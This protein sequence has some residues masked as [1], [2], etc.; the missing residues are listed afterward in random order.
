VSSVLPSVLSTISEQFA[1][2]L[3]DDRSASV[4]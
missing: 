3:I 1:D 4:V 2:L